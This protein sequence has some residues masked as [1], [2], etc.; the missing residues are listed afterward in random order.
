LCCFA[1]CFLALGCGSSEPFDYL[2][3]HGKVTYDDGTPVPGGQLQFT[4]EAPAKGTMHPRP[5]NA[6]IKPDGTFDSATTH[7]FGDGLVPG[8]H[9]VSFIFATDANG[10]SL[11][12]PAY[13]DSSS[14][15]LEIDTANQPIEIKVPKPTEPA[16]ATKAK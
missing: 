4:S 1:A 2:P 10:K 12:P 8:K 9:K 15:P 5:G 14:S 16:T 7:T 13:S 3:V 11:V 6:K